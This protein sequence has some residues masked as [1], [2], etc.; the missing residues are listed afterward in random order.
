MDPVLTQLPK[1]PKRISFL[2]ADTNQISM[3]TPSADE[4]QAVWLKAPEQLLKGLWRDCD[5]VQE[6]TFNGT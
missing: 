4:V 1:V 5:A 2:K 3:Q 6:L